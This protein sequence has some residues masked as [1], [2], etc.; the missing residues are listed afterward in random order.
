MFEW[1]K[2]I[3]KMID[4]IEKQIDSNFNEEITLTELADKLGYSKFHITKQFK[5][6]TQ[7]TFRNYLRFRRLA[8]S[9]MALRDSNKRIIDSAVE[10]GFSSQ[11]AYTRAFKIAY[12]ITPNEYRKKKIPL[13]LQ[14]K[15][16]R[17]AKP[18][19]HAQYETACRCSRPAPRH[20]RPAPSD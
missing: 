9:V 8:Y 14:T 3:Q 10:F 4:I 12:G 17:G 20:K 1:H 18:P 11:E 5:I 16:N 7:I 2:T 15:Q 13:I 6:L 19:A